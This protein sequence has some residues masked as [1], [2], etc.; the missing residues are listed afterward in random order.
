MTLSL[1]PDTL[2]EPL[3][4]GSGNL[5]SVG[6]GSA[7]GG[8]DEA[9]YDSGYSYGFVCF[10]PVPS[11]A[12]LTSLE[13]FIYVSMDRLL[14]FFACLGRDITRPK[15]PQWMNNGTIIM[16]DEQYFAIVMMGALHQI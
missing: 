2:N 9:L 7:T 11:L 8:P 15:L 6:W 13:S 4:P 10:H 12:L 5:T 3:H 16:R 14:T 1:G